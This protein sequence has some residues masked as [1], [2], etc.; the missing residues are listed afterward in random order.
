MVTIIALGLTGSDRHFLQHTMP[1]LH[2][3]KVPQL[4][5]KAGAAGSSQSGQQ[6]SLQETQPA[7]GLCPAALLCWQRD[8]VANPAEATGGCRLGT[9]QAETSPIL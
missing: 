6:M 4:P 2:A 7:P 5:G 1:D 9:G 8:A 3:Q